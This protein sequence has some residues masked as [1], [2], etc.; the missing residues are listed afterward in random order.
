MSCCFDSDNNITDYRIY[1]IYWKDVKDR[2]NNEW[3]PQLDKFI[4]N[5]KWCVDP[6][7]VNKAKAI[8]I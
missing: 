5:V 6:H 7:Y 1:R 8:K 3:Y 2:W 4:Q